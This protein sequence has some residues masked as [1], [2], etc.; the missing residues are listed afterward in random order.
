M[1]DPTPHHEPVVDQMVEVWASL[2]AACTQ[3]DTAEW[4][5]GTDCPGWS[6]KDQV[7]HVIGI[8]RMILGDP[9]PEPLTEIPPYVVNELGRINESWVRSRRTVPGG[10]VLAELVEV[11]DRRIDVLASMGREDFDRVG[12][13]PLGEAPYRRFMET[14]IVDTWAHEQDIRTALGRPGGRNGA[15]ESVALEGCALTMPYVVGKRVAPPERTSVLFAVTG[16]LGRETLV[17][18][19]DGRA[20]IIPLPAA[21]EPSVTLTM[22]Q[23]VFWRL[24]YGRVD[25]SQVVASG[26]VQ[27]DGDPAL[28]HRI[29]D[30]MSFMR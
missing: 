26:G 17:A 19:S 12:W 9:S 28:G 16:P 30:S 13:S 5:L 11:I 3:V 4:E 1:M 6:V 7:A 27:V 23:E 18:M 22:A 20:S 24:S 25:A 14:R 2:I 10:E 29:L 15:G 8:E 21:R